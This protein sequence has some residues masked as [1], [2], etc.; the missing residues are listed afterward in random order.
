MGRQLASRA[1]HTAALGAGRTVPG[2]SVCSPQ[3]QGAQG[4]LERTNGD[5]ALHPKLVQ[6]GSSREHGARQVAWGH[7]DRGA[8]G[9]PR[10]GLKGAGA[11]SAFPATRQVFHWRRR[12]GMNYL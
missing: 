4:A 12:K 7:C 8:S 10:A 9:G 11:G 6:E 3:L 5:G 1:A 2:T